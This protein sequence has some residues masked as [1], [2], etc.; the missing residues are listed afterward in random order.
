MDWTQ[1]PG[2]LKLPEPPGSQEVGAIPHAHLTTS[3][4]RENACPPEVGGGTG[5]ALRAQ[6]SPLG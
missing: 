3:G 4:G 5:D 6:P 1:F 2:R